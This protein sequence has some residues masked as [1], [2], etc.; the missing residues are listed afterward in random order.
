MR[1]VQVELFVDQESKPRREVLTSSRQCLEGN[2]P[3]PGEA[4][5]RLVWHVS[6]LGVEI[7]QLLGEV[8]EFERLT[9]ACRDGRQ[10]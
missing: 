4:P 1:S 2:R 3:Q 8:R 7:R 10:P 5:A 6:H 9:Q